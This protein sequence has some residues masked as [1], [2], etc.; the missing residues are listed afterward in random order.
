MFKRSIIFLLVFSTLGNIIVAQTNHSTTAIMQDQQVTVVYQWTAKPGQ[1]MALKAIYSEVEK[2]MKANEPGALDVQ[3]YFDEAA[4]TLVVSDLFANAEALGFHLGTTAAAHFP[5]LLEI[6]QP[7]PFLF[8][9]NI[10]EEMKQAAL[11]MGL[12]A[13]FAPSIFGFSRE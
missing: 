11:G 13:T 2:Q 1:P 8:C 4:R 7:G 12:N 3:C 6:A 10:P 5:Q 9:G